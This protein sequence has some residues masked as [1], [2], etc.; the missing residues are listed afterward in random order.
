M[1]KIF[2]LLDRTSD[3]AVLALCVFAVTVFLRRESETSRT[4]KTRPV[5][6]YHANWRSFATSGTRIGPAAAPVQVMELADF[7]CPGCRAF[8]HAWSAAKARFGNAIAL[9]YVHYPLSYHHFALLSATAVECASEQGRFADMYALLFSQQD[10]IG[11]KSI[12]AFA[13]D[14][15]VTDSI[16]FRTCISRPDTVPAV[17]RGLALG[18]ALSLRATP[19]ILVNGLQLGRPPSEDE[20]IAIIQR[21]LA[22]K[23]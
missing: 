14:A 13:R 22:E 17:R 3:I 10:S 5:D 6:I 23:H 16:A 8:Y 15:H 4:R 18:K 11:T 9:T 12:Y 19:T 7:E 21:A 20:L 1:S 2:S